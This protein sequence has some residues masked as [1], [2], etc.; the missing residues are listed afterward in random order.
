[1]INTGCTTPVKWYFPALKNKVYSKKRNHSKIKFSN[2][3]HIYILYT[4]GISNNK[5][6][7]LM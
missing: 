2:S 4:L 6:K 3:Y 5:K 7:L 1:M